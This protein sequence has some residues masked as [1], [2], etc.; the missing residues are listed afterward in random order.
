MADV[1]LPV[2]AWAEQGGHFLSLDGRLQEAR[3]VLQAP[4]GVR[5]NQA[6]LAGLAA[7]LNI[8]PRVDWKQELSGRVSPVALELN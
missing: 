8:D 6:V 7:C 5:T 2:T 3:A 4:Q 1:V